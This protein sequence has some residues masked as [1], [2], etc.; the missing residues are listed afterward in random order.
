MS[1]FDNLVKHLQKKQETEEQTIPQQVN[2]KIIHKPKNVSYN[3]WGF[4]RRCD[5]FEINRH[6]RIVELIHIKLGLCI[7]LYGMSV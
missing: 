7:Y 1:P 5:D 2:D 6:E 4:K 3:D